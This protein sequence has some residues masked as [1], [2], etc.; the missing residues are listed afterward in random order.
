[1]ILM[2]FQLNTAFPGH[3]PPK[4]E[5]QLS[6]IGK[7]FFAVFFGENLCNKGCFY[8]AEIL[9]E[10]DFHELEQLD[11][12]GKNLCIAVGV[13]AERLADSMPWKQQSKLL[14]AVAW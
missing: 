7:F 4:T 11:E 9:E 1:M 13:G 14:E 2:I 3:R 5:G 10:L 12:G 6:S 8:I